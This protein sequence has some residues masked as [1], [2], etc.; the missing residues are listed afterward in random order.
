MP[1]DMLN[2]T[3]TAPQNNEKLFKTT[4]FDSFKNFKFSKAVSRQ[5]DI[6]YAKTVHI[7]NTSIFRLNKHTFFVYNC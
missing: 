5:M 3:S 7:N 1:H 2:E 6:G 4:T